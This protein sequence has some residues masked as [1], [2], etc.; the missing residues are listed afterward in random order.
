MTSAVRAAEQ[1]TD[2]DW[3]R[4]HPATPLLKG[5]IALLAIAGVLIA[6]L[7]ER[8]I[9]GFFG[10]GPSDDDP[11]SLLYDNGLLGWALLI[12]LGG[13][14]LT[15]VGFYVSWRMHEFRVTDEVV[16]VR[17]GILFRTNRKG[18]LDRIQGINIMRPFVARLFG[19]AKLEV[20][21]AGQNANVQLSYLRSKDADTLRRE[22][23]L[24]ASGK[25]AERAG[26]SA[27][28]P[29]TDATLH[30]TRGVSAPDGTG[31]PADGHPAE[32]HRTAF[33]E[34]RAREFLSPELDPDAAPPESVVT[35]PVGRLIGSILLSGFTIAILLVILVG[36]PIVVAT[37]S[38]WLLLPV[39][40]G[41]IGSIG[42]YVSRVMRSL[43]YSIA[44]TPDGIRV[45]YGLLSTSNDTL[46]PGRIHAVEVH[47]P[48]LWRIPGWWSIRI[49]KASSSVGQSAAAQASSELLPVGT[50][51]DVARVLGL[52]LP[53]FVGETSTSLIRTGML[54]RGAPDDG[55]VNAPR[56]GRILR[57]LSWRR[58]GFAIDPTA[59]LLRTGAVWRHLVI[60]PHARLQSI[61]LKQGPL[62]R[63]LRI[64]RVHAH[65]VAGPVNSELPGVDREVA[66]QLYLDLAASAAQSDRTDRTH[67]WNAGAA[68][69]IA[70]FEGSAGADGEVVTDGAPSREEPR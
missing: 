42:F 6:N 11:I 67:R 61:A 66:V 33:L 7:R 5:G 22:I 70:E 32:G 68:E 24:L 16:E 37:G 9:E 53:E 2:G 3:H 45:G 36:I 14:L 34:E 49:T 47:Q 31:Q 51:G 30:G 55:F 12:L 54:G 13:V 48:L 19:A 8:I 26:V 65:T 57:P 1:L 39:L 23:L 29:A 59:L 35:I 63:A 40:P 4:L 20:N 41:L 44:G 62:E 18:R 27:G 38:Y 15:M 58:T 28:V 17:S 60:V 21:V 52:I 56:R 64:A 50:L 46:P 10:G 69:L 25:R 43:R